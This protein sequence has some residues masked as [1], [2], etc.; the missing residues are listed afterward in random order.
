MLFLLLALLVFSNVQAQSDLDKANLLYDEY[1][2][3]EAI[4]FYKKSLD[5]TKT[6]EATERL[7]DCYRF[8]GL[9]QDAEQWY[10]KVITFPDYN[11]INLYY[12]A[13]AL[14]GNT[15]YKEA[16]KQYVFYSQLVPGEKEEIDL[17]AKSCEVAQKWI[18][19]PEPVAITNVR[20]L[21]TNLADFFPIIWKESNLVFT[22]E[23]KISADDEKKYGWTGNPYLK[24][25]STS[26]ID[27]SYIKISAFD[28]IINAEF[29]NGPASFT[30]S[31]DTMYFTR[32]SLL[33][34][35]EVK[36]L[37]NDKEKIANYVDRKEIFS[38]VLRNNVWT[39]VRAFQYNS[40]V[41]YNVQH[42][43][44]SADG[45]MLYFSSDM[46]GGFGLSDLYYCEKINDSTWTKPV[47]CGSKI[48]TK[49]SEGM[50]SLRGNKLYFSSN[51]HM[52]MG[53][54]DLF[55]TEGNRTDWK[56]PENLKY[57]YNSPQDEIG[58]TFKADGTSGFISSL[59]QGGL[60]SDDIYSFKPSAP[61]CTAKGTVV[62]KGTT[63][64]IP[65]AAVK[66]MQGNIIL[67]ETISDDNG[68]FSVALP[69]CNP[70]KVTASKDGYAPATES[71]TITNG[72]LNPTELSLGLQKACTAKGTV[73]IKGTTTV[74]PEAKVKIYSGEDLIA[75]TISDS[76]GGFSAPIPDC[77]PGTITASKT[78]YAPSS[79]PYT[80]QNGTIVP[81]ELT[82]GLQKDISFALEGIVVD[83]ETQKPLE[84]AIVTLRDRSNS[85]S[86]KVVT[87]EDG[88]FSYDLEKNASYTLIGKKDSFFTAKIDDGSISTSGLTVSKVLFAKL[89]MEKIDLNKKYKIENVNFDLNKDIIRPDAA[90]KLDKIVTLMNDNPGITIELSSHTDARGSDKSNYDLS[91]RRAKSSANYIISKGVSAARITGKGY[92]ETQIINRCT[93]G[94]VC[95]DK[96]HEENRRT[97]FKVTSIKGG[98]F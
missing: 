97:E 71:Y 57:P 11:P 23:R 31:G 76:K 58:I 22:S 73:V 55:V 26:I 39:N 25:F 94:V 89:E 64:V 49:Y 4:P 90:K 40:V 47:N 68:R 17:I 60:G 72:I 85:K 65:Q 82:L 7:A 74:I 93:E 34:I 42:P 52:G 12:Y 46:P 10:A 41:D 30:K 87:N 8:N 43:A 16:Q 32:V 38:A 1:N 91:D 96:E 21:N 83:K 95:T 28:K 86:I 20:K 44:I 54:L 70:G 45:N 36:K 53:G 67:A 29:H 19:N 18:D 92:G 79:E 48:N 24:L 78:G 13:E 37:T 77:K 15:K 88:K 69:N 5:K 63:I 35:K 75:E 14:R 2:Y 56:T 61:L 66:V 98:I 27:S 59:R 62:Q 9:T 3:T 6:L 84:D 33:P 81:A 51:G 80:V 50:P